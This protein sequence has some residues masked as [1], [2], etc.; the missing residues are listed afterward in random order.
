[1]KK[2]TRAGANVPRS[3]HDER[4]ACCS[5]SR[6]RTPSGGAGTPCTSLPSV[7][8]GSRSEVSLCSY[9][10]TAGRPGPTVRTRRRARHNRRVVSCT[11][12]LVS[13]LWSSQWVNEAFMPSTHYNPPSS[14]IHTREIRPRTMQ[15]YRT[16]Y[17]NARV[18]DHSVCTLRL[19]IL[20]EL[21]HSSPSGP[22]EHSHRQTRITS[23]VYVLCTHSGLTRHCNLTQLPCAVPVP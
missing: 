23:P 15:K 1:M 19:P 12:R 9:Q 8:E 11:W 20:A 13:S 21:P 6:S 3:E 18:P 17:G 7:L 14:I 22:K 4:L 16:Q 10:Q 2:R 5:G